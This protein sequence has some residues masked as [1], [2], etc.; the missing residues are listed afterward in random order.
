MH[1]SPLRVHG[2]ATQFWSH[3]EGTDRL[4]TD[5]QTERWRWNVTASSG[6]ASSSSAYCTCDDTTGNGDVNSGHV[7]HSIKN[8]TL[9]R[10]N[11]HFKFV[12]S[13]KMYKDLP[14]YSAESIKFNLKFCT[15]KSVQCTGFLFRGFKDGNTIGEKN[16]MLKKWEERHM[17]MPDGVY[18]IYRTSSQQHRDYIWKLSC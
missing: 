14:C 17:T 7:S 15:E 2:L 4:K 13:F 5:T 16:R 6:S 1:H 3:T 9:K 10:K 8:F 12:L 11:N 18:Y